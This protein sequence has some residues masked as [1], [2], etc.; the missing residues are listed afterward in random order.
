MRPEATLP[1]GPRRVLHRAG[2][3]GNARDE[4]DMATH[5]V[6]GEVDASCT[7]C[8]MELAHTI[9]AMVGHEDRPRALQHLR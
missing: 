7:R 3:P 5:R 9:L 8:K 2:R 4:T 1:P 6:G